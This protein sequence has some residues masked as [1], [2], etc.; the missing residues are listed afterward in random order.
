[1]AIGN[2][3]RAGV[4]TKEYEDEMTLDDASFIVAARAA[5]PALIAEIERLRAELVN[6]KDEIDELH[7]WMQE[8]D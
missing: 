8:H 7:T 2:E 3:K 5:V 4:L 6:A 1:M